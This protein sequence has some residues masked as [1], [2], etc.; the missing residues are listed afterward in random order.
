MECLHPVCWVHCS[1]KTQSQFS[2]PWSAYPGNNIEL[3]G[4]GGWERVNQLTYTADLRA[5]GI[6]ASF[7]AQD[8]V[9]NYTTNIWNVSGATAAGLAAGVY[10]RCRRHRRYARSRSRRDASC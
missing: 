9:V 6:T 3:P 1:G 2:S 10:V 8:Q 4:G 7:S 5:A